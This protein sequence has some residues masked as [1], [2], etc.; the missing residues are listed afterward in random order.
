M[1]T[2]RN[3]AGCVVHIRLD[4]GHGPDLNN[5]VRDIF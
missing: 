5:S 1:G 2:N 3:W 4:P